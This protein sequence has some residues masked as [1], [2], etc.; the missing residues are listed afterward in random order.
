MVNVAGSRLVLS[1]KRHAHDMRTM[2]DVSSL[3]Q[4]R[5]SVRFKH[6]QASETDESI[7]T[8]LPP[9]SV[10][11]S[12]RSRSARSS[13]SHS[14]SLSSFPVPP[15]SVPFP[16]GLPRP[17][18]TTPSD[19][20][21]SNSSHPQSTISSVSPSTGVHT[22]SSFVVG[23]DTYLDID[24]YIKLQELHKHSAYGSSSGTNS[25]TVRPESYQIGTV[26]P[27]K[28]QSHWEAI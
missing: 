15:T 18:S 1:L 12:R 6:S 23:R 17:T 13:P 11:H 24:E 14:F 16:P 27:E 7:F 4:S 22:S 26:Y 8:R 20:Y 3:G 9:R 21:S 28:Y 25:N 10:R 5:Y 2:Q 19:F